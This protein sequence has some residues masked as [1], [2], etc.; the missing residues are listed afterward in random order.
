MKKIDIFKKIKIH[1]QRE[2]YF[3][4]RPLLSYGECFLDGKREKYIDI[5]PSKSFKE[6]LFD[7]II[8]YLKEQNIKYDDIY[9]A[10]LNI[11]ETVLLSGLIKGWYKKMTLKNP[12]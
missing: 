4:N 6:K 5:F 3:F 9:I 1:K 7:K 10:R 11:G 2:L 12:Y 8:N